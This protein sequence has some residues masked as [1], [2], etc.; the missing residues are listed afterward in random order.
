MSELP[1]DLKDYKEPL[2]AFQLIEPSLAYDL[3]WVALIVALVL[4]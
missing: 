2:G 3:F 1:N 4:L